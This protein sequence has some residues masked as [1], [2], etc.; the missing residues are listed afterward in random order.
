MA[1]DIH[2]HNKFHCGACDSTDL[3]IGYFGLQAE[4]L[5]E[6]V[7]VCLDCGAWKK[8]QAAQM[9]TITVTDKGR[10]QDG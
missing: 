7:I 8:Y 2:G 4:M 9:G 6:V 10:Q 1:D 5:M 3:G